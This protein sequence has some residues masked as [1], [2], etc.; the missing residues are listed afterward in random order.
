[1][2]ALR[3]LTRVAAVAAAVALFFAWLI[4]PARS[5]A[6]CAPLPDLLRGIRDRLGEWVVMTADAPGGRYYL[7]RSDAGGWTLI[8]ARGDV[9]CVIL[10]GQ[11]SEIIR[12]F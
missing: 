1:M 9:G 10:G 11:D 7:T 12:G 6:L 8:F 5:Q 2:A 4:V 3:F